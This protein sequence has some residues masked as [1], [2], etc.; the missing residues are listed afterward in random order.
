VQVLPGDVSALFGLGDQREGNVRAG[1]DAQSA[2][3]ALQSIHDGRLFNGEG[4]DWTSFLAYLAGDTT[5]RVHL[6]LVA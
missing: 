6:G 2:S 3:D 4:T 5:I 1:P